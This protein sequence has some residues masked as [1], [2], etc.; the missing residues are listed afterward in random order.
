MATAAVSAAKKDVLVA[1]VFGALTAIGLII[2]I[3]QSLPESFYLSLPTKVDQGSAPPRTACR[4][5][6][7][8]R[9]CVVS[10]R[11]R[12]WR[13]H[14]P[15]GTPISASRMRRRRVTRRSPGCD[16]CVTREGRS[17]GWIDASPLLHGSR[18]L[19]EEPRRPFLPVVPRMTELTTDR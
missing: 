12:A 1:R 15:N 8:A 4:P 5:P 10:P 3:L 6:A 13:D 11:I 16:A 14:S 19:R 9:V 18:S 17:I 7:M 2:A